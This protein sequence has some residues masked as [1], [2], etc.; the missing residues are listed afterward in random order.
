MVV[1]KSDVIGVIERAIQNS[2]ALAKLYEKLS[3]SEI[4]DVE[5]CVESRSFAGNNVL[6]YKCW[7]INTSRFHTIANQFVTLNVYLSAEGKFIVSYT[8]LSRGNNS[9]EFE[10]I[11]IE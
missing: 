11:T 9:M 6:G 3:N 2:A 5:K 8:I 4:H 1:T 7:R 10:D